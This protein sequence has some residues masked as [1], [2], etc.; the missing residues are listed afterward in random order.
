VTDKDILDSWKEISAYLGKEVRTCVRWEKELGLP[1]HRIDSQSSRSPVFAYK[2]EVDAWLRARANG[3]EERRPL[4]W[5]L[6]GAAGGVLALAAV[7]YALFLQP[8]A[9]R[10]GD[11]PAG[12][13]AGPLTVAVSPFSDEAGGSHE[14]YFAAGIAREIVSGLERL[15]GIAVVSLPQAPAGDG[16][17]P[18]A[19]VTREGPWSPDYHLRGAISRENNKAALRLG[20]FKAGESKPIWSC[21]YPEP[22][23]KLDAVRS[24][25]IG[26]I[27]STLDLPRAAASAGGRKTDGNGEAY[28]DYLK[29]S[30]VLSRLKGEARDPWVLY[31]QGRYYESRF[32][33]ADNELAISLFRRA[34]S[35][36]PELAEAYVG[37]ADCYTNYVNM[38]WDFRPGWLTKAEDILDKVEALK[39]DLPQ[40]LRARIAVLMMRKY[41]FGEDTEAALRPLAEEAARK[42]PRDDE[43]NSILASYHFRKYGETGRAGDLDGALRFKEKSFWANPYAVRNIVYAEM[44]LLKGD[45]EAAVEVCSALE[46]VDA[47]RMAEFFLGEIKYYQGDLAGSE[48]IFRR[49]E[50]PNKHRVLS[51]YYLGM[52][53]ARRGDKR[54]ASKTLQEIELLS[55]GGYNFFNDRLKLASIRLG[56]GDREPG[57]RHLEHVLSKE[58]AARDRFL[59]LRYIA[60]DKNFDGVREEE[61]F[62]KLINEGDD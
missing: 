41:F 38:N 37:L 39:A 31:H 46:R 55:P 28:E 40:Y 1:V 3:H 21:E 5:K 23:G 20:F 35:F 33:A 45:F 59:R 26:R 50:T 16:A 36:D 53:Q 49:F 47:S 6:A 42:Y 22:A 15:D 11:S 27:S 7:L 30:Y 34:I 48:E 12:A 8:G 10:E 19:G 52:I 18:K 29:G 13:A 44:L 43:L 54:G 25:V 32:T 14:R 60:L 62:L 58:E 2:E 61:R 56:M 57:Y 17:A 4:P 9:G 51:L 24:E